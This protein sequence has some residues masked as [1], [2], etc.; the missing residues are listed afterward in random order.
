VIPLEAGAVGVKFDLLKLST[1]VAV[2]KAKL[3][4]GGASGRSIVLGTSA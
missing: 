2:L 1:G 4:L 3:Q